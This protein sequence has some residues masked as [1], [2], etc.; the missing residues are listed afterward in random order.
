VLLLLWRLKS[1]SQSGEWVFVRMGRKIVAA[2]FPGVEV[3]VV[4]KGRGEG[5]GV[6][7]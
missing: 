7:V 2:P 1:I 6:K 4:G 3:E 5:K